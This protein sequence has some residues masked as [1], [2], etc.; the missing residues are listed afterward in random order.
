M[1]AALPH[2]V[3][4]HDWPPIPGRPL[5]MLDYDGTLAPIVE[6]PSEAW[7]HPDA[8]SLLARLSSRHPVV[9]VTGRDLETLAR[10]LSGVEGKPPPLRAV[11]L[12]GAEEGVL[13][14]PASRHSFGP[15]AEA[16]V[17][18]RAGVPRREGIT[19]EDKGGDAFAVHYRRSPAQVEAREALER[20]AAGAPEGLEA[21][22]GKCVVEMRPAG[23]SKGVAVTALAE[24]H[25]GC[26]P[27]YLGDDVTDEEAFAALNAGDPDAVTVRVGA[28][29]TGARY[30]V[31]DVDAAIRYLKVFDDE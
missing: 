9:V 17:H 6:D 11:G 27:V 2:P 22:W 4:K 1:E 26:T 19:I 25:T 16:L 8:P 13:G 28:G 21:V 18:L 24:K 29:A 12:H 23:V 10:L 30:R 14:R 3:A 7:P 31:H 5:L 15:I 20:W